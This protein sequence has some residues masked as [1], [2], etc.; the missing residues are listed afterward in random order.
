[1]SDPSAKR[2][3]GHLKEINMSVLPFVEAMFK[4]EDRLLNRL[5]DAGVWKGWTSSVQP[6]AA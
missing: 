1:M 4:A 5:Q 6:C 2:K 3:V